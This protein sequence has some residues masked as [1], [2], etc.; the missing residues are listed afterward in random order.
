MAF[1]STNGC[2]CDNGHRGGARN[3]DG[4]LVT[5]AADATL[6]ELIGI[7]GRRVLVTGAA[8]GIGLAIARALAGCG[9]RVLLTDRDPTAL[10]AACETLHDQVGNARTAVAD[11][12]SPEQLAEAVA[13]MTQAWGGVD[14]AF[15]NAGVSL[16]PGFG[17]PAG[18]LRGLD[19][20]RWQQVLD[21]NLKG[22]LVTFQAVARQMTAQGEGSIVAIASTAGLRA[23]PLVGYSYAASK[24]AIINIVRQAAL[25]LAPR[26]VRVNA[27]AP[28]PIAGTSIGAPVAAEAAIDLGPVWA[29][30]VPLGGR[31]GRPSELAGMA[32][33]LASRASSF[34]TGA[35]YPVDGG[36]LIAYPM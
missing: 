32:I 19:W 24:A 10:A 29:K 25:E 5:A 13:V 16:T 12:T 11:V 7:D 26:G 17:F 9:A 3:E 21:I 2:T 27:I 14:A 30:T 36:A 18:E 6:G 4:A 28:G 33:L 22:A 1:R 31:M 20:R 34:M 15:A 8:S 35:V 23:D